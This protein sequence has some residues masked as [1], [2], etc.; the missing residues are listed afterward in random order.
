MPAQQVPHWQP[1][2][3]SCWHVCARTHWQVVSLALLAPIG[4][5][6]RR[7]RRRRREARRAGVDTDDKSATNDAI[8]VRAPQHQITGMHGHV[9]RL[10]ASRIVRYCASAPILG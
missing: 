6:R 7:R 5:W 9:L 8:I 4:R 1:S 2:L 3:N 10:I